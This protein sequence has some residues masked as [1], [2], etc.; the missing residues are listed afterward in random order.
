[1]DFDLYGN[2]NEEY[3]AE[4]SES[5]KKLMKKAKIADKE[6]EAEIQDERNRIEKLLVTNQKY[7]QLIMDLKIYSANNPW[8]M[9]SIT[10][11]AR[12]KNADNPGYVIQ[13]WLR[14][15]NTLEFLRLWEKEHNSSQFNDEAAI[16]L[17]ERTHEPSFTITA[18]AWINETNAIGI[19]SKQG[20]NGGT[21]AAKQIAI[22]FITWL[23][24]E[25]RYELMKIISKR[26]F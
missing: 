19:K 25:K 3:M 1:M 22:D 4:Y 11:Y 15:R 10:Q 26:I 17:I 23:N 18:K 14:D 7:A 5:A 13:S 9:V 24:P 16:K 8:D 2:A 12:R 20:A 6:I 21:F